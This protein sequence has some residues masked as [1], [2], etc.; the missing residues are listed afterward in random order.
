MGRR[1]KILMLAGAATGV[2]LVRHRGSGRRIDGGIVMG[3]AA[4]YDLQARLLLGSF[5]NG[6]AADVASLTPAGGR[7]LEVGCGP[8]H[9][10][11]RLA[12]RHL[13]DVTGIDLDPAMIERAR[14]NA[15][16]AERSERTPPSLV[17]GDVAALPFPDGSFDLVVSTLSMHHWDDPATGLAEI[18]RV[19]RPG[20]RALVWDLRAGVL[21]SHR[22]VRNAAALA[23]GSRLRVASATLW[24]WPWRLAL[25]RR[26]ELLKRDDASRREEA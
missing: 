2:A 14:A 15:A 11:L 17:E 3:D 13:L 10:A 24:H 7:V 26:V 23:D 6:V 12:D 21:P 18:A 16:R 19:L 1:R 20:G 4:R 22:R 9:L 25:S 8:G 5:F